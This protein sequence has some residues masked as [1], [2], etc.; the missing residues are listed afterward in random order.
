MALY[1][2]LIV[3]TASQGSCLRDQLVSTFCAEPIFGT[4]LCSTLAAE[5]FCNFGGWWQR[6]CCGFRSATTNSDA[7][8]CH[9]DDQY[10][11]D[12]RG[13]S[14]LDRPGLLASDLRC[15]HRA[16]CNAFSHF[17]GDPRAFGTLIVDIPRPNRETVAT[18]L[19]S[20]LPCSGKPSNAFRSE[21][22]LEVTS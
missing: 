3:A 15:R 6:L 14:K 12:N 19:G 16:G 22:M 13:C 10:G 18:P 9:Q 20:G 7:D 11:K 21:T 4:D 17:E 2:K 8:D 5:L 1:T